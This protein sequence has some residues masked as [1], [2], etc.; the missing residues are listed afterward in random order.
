[1]ATKRETD[2]AK[3]DEHSDIASV[4]DGDD[5]MLADFQ[6]GLV[7]LRDLADEGFSLERFVSLKDKQS[8]M[9]I[10]IG[11]GSPVEFRKMVDGKE[12]VQIARTWRLK[13]IKADAKGIT[14]RLLGASQL[15]SRL[16][17]TKPGDAVCIYRYGST[18]SRGGY[19]VN[20]YDIAVRPADTG[21]IDTTAK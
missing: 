4:A 8:I 20:L 2:L 12:V 15:N 14:V 19:V 13:P 3:R 9:G 18:R 11:E 17:D 7:N 1:M 6:C 5:S 21:V 10:L 16:A